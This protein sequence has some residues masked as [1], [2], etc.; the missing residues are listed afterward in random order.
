MNI[1]FNV[2]SNIESIDIQHCNLIDLLKRGILFVEGKDTSLV[3]NSYLND[4]YG[5]TAYHFKNEENL[6]RQV[7][8]NDIDCHIRTHSE[9][10]VRIYSLTVSGIECNDKVSLGKLSGLVGSFVSHVNDEDKKFFTYYSF[11][12]LDSLEKYSDF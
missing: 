11:F 8:Y 5:Y 7:N 9:L 2:S 3:R 6:M 12:T 10:L 1:V 4:L